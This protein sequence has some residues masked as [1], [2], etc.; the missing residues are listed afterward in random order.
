MAAN[1]RVNAH[2]HRRRG[3]GAHCGIQRFAH[4]M[5]ALK[6]EIAAAIAQGQNRAHG[7]RIVGRKL[8]KKRIR[9][10]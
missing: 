5:Q 7:M 9:R 8:G 3:A 6:F 10:R 2:R 4:A 1:R